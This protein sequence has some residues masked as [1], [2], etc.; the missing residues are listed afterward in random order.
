MWCCARRAGSRRGDPALR[1]P[2]QCIGGSGQW[3]LWRLRAARSM[4]TYRIVSAGGPTSRGTPRCRGSCRSCWPSAPGS[5]PRTC[6]TLAVATAIPGSAGPSGSCGESRPRGPADAPLRR[7]PGRVAARTGPFPRSS[8]CWMTGRAPVLNQL[9]TS[10]CWRGA[11]RRRCGGTAP[12]EMPHEVV[13]EILGGGVAFTR[14]GRQRPGAR[15]VTSCSTQPLP[16]G[17]LKSAN[18]A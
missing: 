3:S 9:A 14:P 18:D 10:A 17:S 4:T 5:G 15:C 6:G 7:C 13:H 1:V 12:G 16:S 8:R 11:I 2:Y